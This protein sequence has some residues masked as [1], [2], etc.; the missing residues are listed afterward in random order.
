MLV[1]IDESGDPGNSPAPN[2][3]RFFTITLVVFHD[4]A[5]ALRVEERI[6]ELRREL[7]LPA[8]FEF[9]FSK[10]RNEWRTRFFE[11]TR[12]FRW[13][14][15]SAVINKA[16]LYGPGFNVPD[17]FYKYTCGRAFELVGPYLREA[18]VVIDSSG[19]RRF[20]EELKAYLRK[21]LGEPDAEGKRPIK[22]VKLEESHR[23]N[24]LQ[25]ADMVC[26]AVTRDINKPD[27]DHKY[28]R[29]IAH[30][31]SVRQIWP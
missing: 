4:H 13:T 30:R 28:R 8:S 19:N 1:F 17:S 20:R 12:G 10:L 31:E 14:Y 3:S 23:N 21:R 26:G 15:F 5:E 25:L 9:H 16:K 27:E 2:C 29:L 6:I 11:T 24:L 18:I 7:R 22:K